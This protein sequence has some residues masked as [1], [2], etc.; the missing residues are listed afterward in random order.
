MRS[1][2][3]YGLQRVRRSLDLTAIRI[4]RKQRRRQSQYCDSGAELPMGATVKVC[5]PHLAHKERSRSGYG[6]VA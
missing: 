6:A 4:R 2:H 5:I 1:G 3:I